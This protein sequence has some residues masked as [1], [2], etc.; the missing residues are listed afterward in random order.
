MSG[1]L[2]LIVFCNDLSAVNVLVMASLSLVWNDKVIVF[3]T[4]SNFAM[5]HYLCLVRDGTSTSKKAGSTLKIRLQSW[6]GLSSFHTKQI[7][8]EF[9]AG[10]ESLTPGI[11]GE[12][13]FAWEIA[14]PVREQD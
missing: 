6:W 3:L 10:L 5:G 2:K 8:Q 1:T 4:F 9:P 11:S 12:V 13:A 7:S 14:N